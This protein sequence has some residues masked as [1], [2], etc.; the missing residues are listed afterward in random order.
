[1]K[2]FSLQTICSFVLAY[3]VLIFLCLSTLSLNHPLTTHC[4]VNNRLLC[5]FVVVVTTRNPHIYSLNV[6]FL[7]L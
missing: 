3:S 1:L 7:T 2:A 6:L 4:L 5:L